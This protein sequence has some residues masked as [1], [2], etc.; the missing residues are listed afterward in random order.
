LYPLSG[1]LSY[2]RPATVVN[3]FSENL[4]IKSSEGEFRNFDWSF[5]KEILYYTLVKNSGA[6]ETEDYYVMNLYQSPNENC[7]L[8][9]YD[10]RKLVEEKIQAGYTPES[11]DAI[12]LLTGN[13]V[14]LVDRFE[15]E[16]MKPALKPHPYD[17]SLCKPKPKD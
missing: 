15:Y 11:Q 16:K 8:Y 6:K 10:S 12:F 2:E 7:Y 3:V 9:S 17:A 1:C 13:G 5:N 14:K 4:Y